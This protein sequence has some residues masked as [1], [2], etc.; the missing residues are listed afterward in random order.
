[1]EVGRGRLAF[2]KTGEG[3]LLRFQDLRTKVEGLDC[4]WDLEML[5]QAAGYWKL[6]IFTG[7]SPAF[8]SIRDDRSLPINEVGFS[9]SFRRIVTTAS[10]CHGDV[11]SGFCVASGGPKMPA[12]A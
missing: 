2:A 8:I 7:N 5:L 4:D 6:F 3:V 12:M 10:L 11:G 1:M 9:H